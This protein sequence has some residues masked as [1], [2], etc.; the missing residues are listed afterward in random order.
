MFR[1]VTHRLRWLA[2]VPG[3]PLIFDAML[4]SWTALARR[5]RLR[6]IEAVEAAA[7]QI[8]GVRRGVH[9]LGGI[10]FI[11]VNREL[12]H[13][14][15]NGLLDVRVG[16]E[17]A[18]I[19]VREN[20]AEPHHLFGESAWIS[21]QMLAVEDVPRAMDLLQIAMRVPAMPQ[22]GTAR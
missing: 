19:L 7:L 17:Q 12:G 4:L 11:L 3:L 18:R 16:A 8:P 2:R 1:F 13:L 21:F 10:E 9:R 22:T 15:G 6:A 5:Q 14:H 20:R